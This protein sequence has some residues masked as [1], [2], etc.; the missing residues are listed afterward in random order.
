[1]YNA[2]EVYSWELQLHITEIKKQCIIIKMLKD[3]I[4]IEKKT[5][6]LRK[7][8]ILVCSIRPS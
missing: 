1:M 2:N 8:I 7:M 3:I 4:E 5:I 6:E